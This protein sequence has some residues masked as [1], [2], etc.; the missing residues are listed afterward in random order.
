[1][2]AVHPAGAPL[3]RA[4]A[5]AIIEDPV[6]GGM[7]FHSVDFSYDPDIGA[8]NGTK[9]LDQITLSIA[10][11]DFV[12]VVG[13]SGSGKSTFLKLLNAL[14]LP[15]KGVV[16]IRCSDTR[17]ETQLW[18]IRRMTGMIFQDPDSQIVGTTVAEDV[19]FGPENLGL[20][21]RLIRERVEDAL[22]AVAME[23]HGDCA[24]HLLSSARKLRVSLAGVLAMQPD[25]ILL[26]EAGAMLDP[27]DRKE[28]MALLRTLNREEGVT[29]VHVTHDMDEA[30][31]ADRVIVLD[32][33]RVALDGG[34]AE[35]FSDPSAVMAA[36][37]DL[38]CLARL[39][40]L[41]RGEG[42]DLAA[43][44]LGVDEAIEALLKL[45]S[46]PRRGDADQD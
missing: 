24:T 21:P 30:A 9:A 25:C 38:P 3:F 44:T 26:D 28:L 31:Q 37:L 46:G 2:A 23:E 12:A 7:E 6:M 5:S 20:S 8:G 19:A 43:G 15:S 27:A 41:L 16:S 42:Y 13:R 29:V 34:P 14:L 4:E 45:R 40:H 32:D 17:D 39:L 36:G 11:G 33:G 22:R 1:M 35:V 18:E 10:R